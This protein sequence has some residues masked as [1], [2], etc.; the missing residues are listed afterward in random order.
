MCMHTSGY[1]K[2]LLGTANLLAPQ[3]HTQSAHTRAC[4]DVMPFHRYLL[5]PEKALQLG[6]GPPAAA[7]GGAPK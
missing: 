4:H 2:C 6:E 5:N 3:L 1:G 7:S